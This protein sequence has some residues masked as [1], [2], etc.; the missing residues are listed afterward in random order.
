LESPLISNPATRAPKRDELTGASS[1]KAI[2]GQR[3]CGPSWI[4]RADLQARKF[5]EGSPYWVTLNETDHQRQ[6]L[7]DKVRNSSKIR[8]VP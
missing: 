8:T 6:R 5:N 2:S 3:V 4:E 1:D 7:R